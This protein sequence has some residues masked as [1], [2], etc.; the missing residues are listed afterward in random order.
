MR[1]LKRNFRQYTMLS[2]SWDHV[3]HLDQQGV[4]YTL[5]RGLIP[6][7]FPTTPPGLSLPIIAHMLSWILLLQ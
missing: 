7:N 1:F 5:P 3:Y 4:F 6:H 2:S